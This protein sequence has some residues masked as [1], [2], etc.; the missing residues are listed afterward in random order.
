MFVERLSDE[1]IMTFLKRRYPDYTVTVLIRDQDRFYAQIISNDPDNDF[2]WR[3]RFSDFYDQGSG[4]AWIKYLY[5]IFGEEYRLAYIKAC[6]KEFKQWKRDGS[7]S[8][9]FLVNI[10]LSLFCIQTLHSLEQ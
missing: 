1:Q 6:N 10:F 3:E 4:D 5:S 2:A 7:P 9:I 8:L